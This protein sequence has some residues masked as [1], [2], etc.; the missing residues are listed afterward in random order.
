MNATRL[1]FRAGW[2]GHESQ[3]SHRH[4]PSRGGCFEIREFTKEPG[5]PARDQI[6]GT[7]RRDRTGA[8]RT[9]KAGR[10]SGT[11]WLWRQDQGGTLPGSQ[12]QECVGSL[13]NVE[14]AARA[15]AESA[16]A[17]LKPQN[18]ARPTLHPRRGIEALCGWHKIWHRE[19]L[20]V[21][22]AGIAQLVEHLICNQGVGGSSPFAG[23]NKL[24]TLDNSAVNQ[25]RTS[26][27]IVRTHSM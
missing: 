27:H 21:S 24:N 17:E 4:R 6:Q 18:P 23:T 2:K 12:T 11:G 9:R 16:I 25:F 1:C 10:R 22:Q 5:K 7:P 14:G 26:K 13:R 3:A 19:H 20:L 15:S 8:S